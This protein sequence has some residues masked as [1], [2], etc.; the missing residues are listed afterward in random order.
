[1]GHGGTLREVR[2]VWLE[3]VVVTVGR[4]GEVG[5]DAPMSF[6]HFFVV[7]ERFGIGECFFAEV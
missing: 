7:R 4:W 6:G 2:D 5:G 1:M 3:L